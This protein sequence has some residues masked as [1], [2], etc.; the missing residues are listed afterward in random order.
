MELYGR[1]WDELTFEDALDLLLAALLMSGVSRDAEEVNSDEA[2]LK[3]EKAK[4]N[5][6][7]LVPVRKL[8]FHPKYGPQ[9]AL[10][11]QRPQQAQPKRRRQPA[12]ATTAESVQERINEH[13]NA[14]KSIFGQIADYYEERGN[15]FA[16]PA[17][18]AFAAEILDRIVNG[19][20]RV[21]G[22]IDRFLRAQGLRDEGPTI[23]SGV[24][25][26]AFHL[27][28]WAGLASD[29]NFA[30]VRDKL[31]E[32]MRRGYGTYQAGSQEY[33][34][35]WEILGKEAIGYREKKIARNEAVATALAIARN[36]ELRE[37]L[38]RATQGVVDAF[39]GRQRCKRA[40]YVGL[41][42]WAVANGIMPESDMVNHIHGLLTAH[43]RLNGI[44]RRLLLW[45]LQEKA[46]AASAVA[47]LPP[48]KVAKLTEKELQSLVEA[49]YQRRTGKQGFYEIRQKLLKEERTRERTY[50]RYNLKLLSAIVENHPF[51]GV[52]GRE[53][54]RDALLNALET[55]AKLL[56]KEIRLSAKI[57]AY[58]R[59]GKDT[60][61]L[62][63]ELVTVK[64]QQ[65]ALKSVFGIIAA[66]HIV[67]TPKLFSEEHEPHVEA[68]WNELTRVV[69]QAM[70]LQPGTRT[71][72]K[73]QWRE[74]LLSGF[75]DIR[76]R[77][78]RWQGNTVAG[79]MVNVL[80]FLRTVAR[81]ERDVSERYGKL[82]KKVKQE[83]VYFPYKP[84]PGYPPIS[85]DALKFLALASAE[86]EPYK[87]LA[88]ILRR[89]V[90][91]ETLAPAAFGVIASLTANGF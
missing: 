65:A 40:F 31:V 51:Y 19:E 35:F 75:D 3:V 6:S 86:G 29:P 34:R 23:T 47:G 88:S 70:K 49:E 14:L 52:K 72:S 82:K 69:N 78:R 56:D 57:E 64:T 20:F 21:G 68:F 87:E 71:E 63:E 32:E 37:Q 90:R 48:E 27:L 74:L 61:R 58:K 15:K 42:A 73:A 83:P 36:G 84:S 7:E 8:R 13:A 11:Y 4:K 89:L 22:H 45:E 76:E 62:E 9:Y 54:Y 18:Q 60:S 50:Y 25:Y 66:A 81:T 91:E 85:R 55:S 30:S 26:T 28:M 77:L 17:V 67:A 53:S 46:L 1:I 43:R 79:M 12:P 16:S 59:Q 39:A 80:N 24:T 2:G 38:E 5:L 33:E 41:G 10:Y 44:R